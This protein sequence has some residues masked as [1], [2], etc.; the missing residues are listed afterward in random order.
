M[1]ADEPSGNLS[2]TLDPDIDRIC[3]EFEV[4]WKS[5]AAPRLEDFL[6]RITD[7]R[8]G[9]LLEHLLVV[10]LRYRQR[11]GERPVLDDFARR[12]PSFEPRV[13]SAFAR[14]RQHKR[15]LPTLPGLRIL[16]VI[17]GGGM[18]IVYKAL[19]VQL[20]S[21][22]AVKMMRSGAHAD[23]HERHRFTREARAVAKLVHPNIVRFF[24]FGEYQ[25][26]P[27]LSMEY[28]D[29]GSLS[30]K[31]E[32]ALPSPDEAAKLVATLARCLK[33]IHDQGVIHRDLK[34]ANV[35]L[36]DD[37]IPKIVDFGLGKRLDQ[38]SKLTLTHARF[39]TPSYMSPE[40][41]K[42]EA[43]KVG[44]PADV[45][46]LGAILYECLTKHPPFKESTNHLTMHK[47]IHDVPL[48]PSDYQPVPVDLEKICLRCL[49]KDPLLRYADAGALADDLERF[50]RREAIS[51]G[52][53]SEA[54]W[55]PRWAKDAGYE[56][57]ELTGCSAAGM[58]YKA[59]QANPLNRIVTLMTLSTR[60]Q[61]D[62]AR[63]AR[64]N[65]GAEAAAQLEHPNIVRIYDYGVHGGQ[66]H[67]S[68]EYLSGGTL[69]ARCTGE[70]WPVREALRT[71]LTLAKAAG[72]AHQHKVVHG[73]LRP[74]NVLLAGDGMPKITGFGLGS[75]VDKD[76][77]YRRGLRLGLSNYMA[78]ERAEGRTHDIGPATDVHALGAMLY[79]LVTGRPP[80]LG[81]DIDQTLAQV[82]TVQPPPLSEVQR[83]VPIALDAICSRCLH[84]NPAERFANGAELAAE[85]KKLLDDD[86]KRTD[87]FELISGYE[88]LEELGRGGLGVTYK[89]RQM[90]LDRLVALKIYR[91]NRRRFLRSNQAA[92]RIAHPHVV[93]IIECGQ[94]E[95]L[96][97]VVEELIE[98]TDLQRLMGGRPLPPHA[99]A[100]LVEVLARALH[101]LH[102]H[103]LVHRNLKPQAILISKLG[104][105]KITGFDLAH[106]LDDAAADAMESGTLAG[107]P[108]YMAPEQLT[109][110]PEAIS[111]AT[112]VY[113][114]GMILY[115][116]LAGRTPFQM[117]DIMQ[118]I[119]DIEAAPIQP[120][121]THAPE[122]PP[123]LDVICLKCLERDHSKRTT[124][125]AEFADELKGW[126]DETGN[127]EVGRGHGANFDW[128]RRLVH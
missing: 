60:A 17:D 121:S 87:D 31:V 94:R 109:G 1:N 116:M 98:G 105:P 111:P 126:L 29:G 122:V 25:G 4:A 6:A 66:P 84:K 73:D 27:Y 96:L 22:V 50:V 51:L 95:G 101:H 8:R 45:Y 58:V 11:G 37:G 93:Q 72:Y 76:P 19:H 115:R 78:P 74:F 40:M 3:D 107:T 86:E 92:A 91:E 61:H 18:G 82:L 30:D 47:V 12:F 16:E 71:I 7:E 49:E 52:D 75:L 123:R 42:G 43:D 65:A 48:P 67:F 85:L 88:L 63:I 2:S 104:I 21:V 62:P 103:R 33:Y 102:E 38:G 77:D 80:F 70:P 10:E 35:L 56:I 13:A 46:G 64:F 54:D 110:S 32:A 114:L 108:T 99:S 106:H 44:I 89:A 24:D 79:E 97:Y 117:G 118:M 128:L 81:D 39:G 26:L 124:S 113:A 112:D 127:G 20:N 41:A 9:A 59:R 23:D 125:A 53:G 69:G 34:P 5:G 68:M 28:V 55:H 15:R 36:T 120:P 100:T 83:D 14:V 119:R 57:L 90:C